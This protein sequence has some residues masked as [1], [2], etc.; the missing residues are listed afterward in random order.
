MRRLRGAVPWKALGQVGG[1][2][3]AGGWAVLEAVDVLANNL[4]LPGWVFRVVLVLFIV[5]LPGV[6]VTTLL[7]H[8]ARA[9]SGHPLRTA[10]TAVLGMALVGALLISIPG[11]RQTG[12]DMLLGGAALPGVG[13]LPF[14]WVGPDA[15]PDSYLA[16]AVP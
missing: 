10:A 3:L 14:G 9:P 5:G 11:V 12:R 15:S 1:L 2:Y 7:L 6:L 8:R 4:E 13:V 16:E